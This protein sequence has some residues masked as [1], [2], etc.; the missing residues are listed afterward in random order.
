MKISTKHQMILAYKC[1]AIT[2]ELNETTKPLI[3]RAVARLITENDISNIRSVEM[4]LL[5][6]ND[7]WFEDLKK[8]C[9]KFLK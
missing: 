9:W 3:A 8:K 2:S 6:L 1:S 7:E 4:E 5:K